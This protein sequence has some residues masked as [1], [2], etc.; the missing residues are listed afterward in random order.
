M[1]WHLHK[2]CFPH[3]RQSGMM[4]PMRGTL[5]LWSVSASQVPGSNPKNFKDVLMV[6]VCMHVSVNSYLSFCVSPVID[7]RVVTVGVDPPTPPDMRIAGDEWLFLSCEMTEMTFL[8]NSS[9]FQQENLDKS[10]GPNT[11]QY[12][13]FQKVLRSTFPFHD[14]SRT[15]SCPRSDPYCS[16]GCLMIS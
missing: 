12:I 8:F 9:M 2:I 5:F 16:S 10:P 1:K 4:P 14:D 6:K 3:R 7:R 13:H 15:R 11:A